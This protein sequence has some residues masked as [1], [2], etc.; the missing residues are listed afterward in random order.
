MEQPY[1][2]AMRYNSIILSEDAWDPKDLLNA[3][4]GKLLYYA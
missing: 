1:H 2:S 4:D 3:I